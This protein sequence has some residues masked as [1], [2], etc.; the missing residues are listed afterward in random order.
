M[1]GTMLKLNNFAS[2]LEG[3]DTDGKNLINE[4]IKLYKMRLKNQQTFGRMKKVEEKNI[5]QTQTNLDLA[6]KQGDADKVEAYYNK[7]QDKGVYLKEPLETIQS[8]TVLHGQVLNQIQDK[9]AV[10][11]RAFGRRVERG[12]QRRLQQGV[13]WPQCRRHQASQ[14]GS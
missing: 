7:L 4:R 2:T 14:A 3:L 13:L 6:V 9:N 5:A 8:R 10:Y 1:E 11:L 12:Q